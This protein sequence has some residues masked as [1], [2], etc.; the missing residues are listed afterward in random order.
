MLKPSTFSDQP[1]GVLK[2]PQV[3]DK[4]DPG[5][6]KAKIEKPFL[7]DAQITAIRIKPTCLF[8]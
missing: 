3:N 7:F 8:P 5:G 2:L 4:L 1:R 6:R